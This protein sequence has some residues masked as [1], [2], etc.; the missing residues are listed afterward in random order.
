MKKYNNRVVTLAVLLSAG[1]ISQ[2][3]AQSNNN[4]LEQQVQTALVTN[5]GEAAKDLTVITSRAY[6]NN[7][8]VICD[9]TLWNNHLSIIS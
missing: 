3:N 9:F 6:C 8:I 4:L 5:M 7:K 1:Y 2:A